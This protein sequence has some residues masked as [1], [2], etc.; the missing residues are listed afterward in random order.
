[1][2]A[3]A[4]AQS[5]DRVYIIDQRAEVARSGLG[6]AGALATGRRLQQPTTSP[7][8]PATRI[9]CRRKMCA[10]G[11]ETHA[12]SRAS[13]EEVRIFT[14]VLKDDQTFDYNKSTLKTAAAE[15][16]MGV[17]AVVELRIG[18]PDAGYQPHR[19][20]SGSRRPTI[21]SCPKT[22]QCGQ[23]LPSVKKGVKAD[24]IETTVRARRSRFRREVRRQ[25][26][27]E[28]ADRLP[29]PNRRTVVEAFAG[30]AK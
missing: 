2:T 1:M 15:L 16:D 14:A 9:C 5:A 17:I 22:C 24:L 28:E 25:A 21:R 12:C 11:T 6:C 3:L 23:G 26:A 4:H 27:E 7:V 18:Q 20:P 10:A 29:A 30:P 8:A 13:T 19:P